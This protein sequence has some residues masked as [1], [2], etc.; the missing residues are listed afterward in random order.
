MGPRVASDVVG[1][2]ARRD[3]GANQDPLLLRPEAPP[4]KRRDDERWSYPVRAAMAGLVAFRGRGFGLGYARN[5]PSQFRGG[6]GSGHGGGREGIGVDP[7]EQRA[8]QALEALARDEGR[9]GAASTFHH[10]APHRR[11]GRLLPGEIPR[12]PLIGDKEEGA[13]RDLEAALLRFETTHDDSGSAGEP[14]AGAG[15]QRA[16]AESG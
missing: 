12:M 8:I 15:A 7:A 1:Q 13:S 9:H 11:L 10:E 16:V 6:D 4:C 5:T 14:E 2:R 3:C